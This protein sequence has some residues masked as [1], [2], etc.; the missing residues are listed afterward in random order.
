MNIVK[1]TIA[2]LALTSY[3]L[4][5]HAEEMSR[6]EA[7]GA[8]LGM[9]IGG[10]AGNKITDK[11]PVGTLLG[12]IVGYNLGKQN[13]K[14]IDQNRQ[15]KDSVVRQLRVSDNEYIDHFG[16][17]A[18]KTGETQRWHNEATGSKGIVRITQQY[19]DYS[20]NQLCR[21]WES[22]TYRQFEESYTHGKG[23][24]CRGFH[25]HASWKIVH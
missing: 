22:D 17:E 20:T 6:S 18:V 14:Q 19:V 13:G 2:A 5:A 10:I 7:N 3:G 1:S 12:G 8:I 15:S 23:T 11:N 9:I 21:S 4:T 16:T 25:E 24:A